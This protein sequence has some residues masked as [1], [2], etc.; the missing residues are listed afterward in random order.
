MY[1]TITLGT[2]DPPGT[3]CRFARV[4]YV[5]THTL[6]A[7]TGIQG[8]YMYMQISTVVH[9]LVIT[10]Q[11]GGFVRTPRTPPGYTPVETSAKAGLCV[12]LFSLVHSN[13]LSLTFSTPVSWQWVGPCHMRLTIIMCNTDGLAG[14]KGTS[15]GF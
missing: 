5:S 13:D 3:H 8:T 9:K 7:Q 12:V 14:S 4:Y 2:V 10:I 1:Y 11:K 6:F 15:R